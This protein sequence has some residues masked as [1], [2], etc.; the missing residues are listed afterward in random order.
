MRHLYAHIPFCLEKCY[1][2][3]FVSAKASPEQREAYFKLLLREA[4]LHQEQ[5]SEKGLLTVYFGGGTPSLLSID[6]VKGLLAGFE[7][8]FGFAK[9]MEITLEA[10]PETVSRRYLKLLR[11]LG[12]N[13]ISFGAQAFQDHHLKAM[14]RIHQ[15]KDISRSVEM[16]REAGFDNINI[17]LIYGLPAQTMAEWQESLTKA[18]ELPITHISTYGLKLSEQT[19]WGRW[20]KEGKLILPEEDLNADMQLFALDYLEEAGFPRYEIANFAKAGYA[21]RHNTAYW[22]RR[23]YLGLGLNASSL[24]NGNLRTSNEADMESYRLKIEKGEFPWAAR[25]ALNAEE[26][27]EE[28]L[29]LALRLIWGL[30]VTAFAKKYGSEYFTQKKGQMVKLFDAGLLTME[31]GQLKLTNKGV[32]LNNEVLSALI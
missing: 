4:Q 6:Q 1:Y 24:L 30:D 14:G 8:N 7:E 31:E 12:V 25:E 11:R 19:L 27:R 18:V 9:K 13:R 21:C 5:R 16:A 26:I 10:N 2:C 17:D 23:D 32:L 3:D 20:L 29:M 15:S 28:E 22:L